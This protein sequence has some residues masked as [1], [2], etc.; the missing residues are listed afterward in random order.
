[1]GRDGDGSSWIETEMGR[2][3][4]MGRRVRWIETARYLVA[5]DG[6]IGGGGSWWV[7]GKIWGKFFFGRNGFSFRV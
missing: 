1:V 4:W 7:E 3:W 2:T 6:R 5:G